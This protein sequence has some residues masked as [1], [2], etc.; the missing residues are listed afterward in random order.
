MKK[1]KDTWGQ[2]KDLAEKLGIKIFHYSIQLRDEILMEPI[3]KSSNH[4]GYSSKDLQMP[5]FDVVSQ[6]LSRGLLWDLFKM[7]KKGKFKNFNMLG[8][9]FL[10]KFVI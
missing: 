2:V 7:F 6:A 4:L 1:L 3:Q 9:K 10:D 8:E 5:S